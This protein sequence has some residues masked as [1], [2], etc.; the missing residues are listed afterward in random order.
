MKGR[1]HQSGAASE[2]DLSFRE[3]VAL[4]YIRGNLGIVLE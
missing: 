2:Y 3:Q 1:K 4:D